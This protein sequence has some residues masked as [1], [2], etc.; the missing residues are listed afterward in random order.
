MKGIKPSTDV[1]SPRLSWQQWLKIVGKRAHGYRPV[2]HT[3]ELTGA[4]ECQTL[5]SLVPC[6]VICEKVF[7]YYQIT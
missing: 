5:T 4:N 2:A 7:K 3:M 1:H 6:P